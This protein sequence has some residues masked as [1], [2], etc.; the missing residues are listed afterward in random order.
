MVWHVDNMKVLHKNKEEVTKS[1]ECMNV[2]YGNNMPVVRV[3]KDT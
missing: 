3:K 2:I 1:I